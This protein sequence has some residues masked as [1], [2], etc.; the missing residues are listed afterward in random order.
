[1]IRETTTALAVKVVVGCVLLGAVQVPLGLGQGSASAQPIPASSVPAIAAQAP[2]MPAKSRPMS[3]IRVIPGSN[4]VINVNPNLPRERNWRVKVERLDGSKWRKVCTCRTKGRYERIVLAQPPGKYRA[5]V[6]P[7]KGYRTTRARTTFT[8][9][10]AAAAETTTVPAV[11]GSPTPPATQVASFTGS[12]LWSADY[13]TGD[14]SQF[15]AAS[16]NFVPLAPSLSTA[17]Q[18]GR[19]AGQYTIPAGG[20]RSENVPSANLTFR[21]GDDRWFTYSTRLAGD[22][23]LNTTNWQ[24]LGQWK[25][26]GVGSPPLALDLDNGRYKIGGGWGWPGTDSPT[27]PKMSK[28]DLGPAT[29]N[30]WE[31]WLF[32]IRFSSDPSEGT[33]DVWRNGTQLVSAWKPIGGTLYPNLSSYWKLGYYR[34]T[35]I[36]QTS[37]V[38][39]D[40]VRAGTTRTAVE[41]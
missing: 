16:W 22:V 26:D 6:L 4:L 15:A 41:R 9:L 39:L 7:R 10:P 12:T 25:N 27:T 21:E 13:E 19:Y 34:S 18:S 29:A 23:P 30:Q 36:G 31:T 11:T 38:L 28:M 32:H 20:S 33:V 1:M 24:V 3:S 37:T 14:F 8:Y 35:A 5:T 2:A 17:A 40:N